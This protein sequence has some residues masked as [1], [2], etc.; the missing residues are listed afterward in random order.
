MGLEAKQDAQR[1]CYWQSQ[2]ASIDQPAKHGSFRAASR[3]DEQEFRTDQ[4]GRQEIKTRCSKCALG[5]CEVVCC[6][7]VREP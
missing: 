3:V 5:R 6:E 4:V 7:V 1:S 2:E